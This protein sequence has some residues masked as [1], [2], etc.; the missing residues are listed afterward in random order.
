[1][2][3]LIKASLAVL[4][5]AAC[6]LAADTDRKHV[7]LDQSPARNN[8]PFSDAVVLGDTLYLAGTVGFDKDGKLPAT[9]EDEAKMA[10]ENVK[11][12]LESQGMTMDDLVS[13]Q[14]FGTDFSLYQ[15][16]NDVY[17]TYFHGQFPARAFIGAASLIRGAHF[18]L[19]GIA[20]RRAK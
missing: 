7:V 17:R 18:E 19:T 4:L 12:V 14:V 5:V 3:Q 9:I 6:S 13:I 11:K 20:V 16:F 10:M 8:F 2:K 15:K 1:M